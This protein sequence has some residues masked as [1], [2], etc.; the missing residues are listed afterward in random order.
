MPAV[1]IT[2]HGSQLKTFIAVHAT[3]QQHCDGVRERKSRGLQRPRRLNAL[4]LAS[5][6]VFLRRRCTYNAFHVCDAVQEPKQNMV[7]LF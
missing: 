2:D 1:S 5:T 3:V 7:T 4:A 6:A